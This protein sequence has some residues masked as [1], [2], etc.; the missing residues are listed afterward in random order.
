ME[1]K[2]ALGICNNCMHCRRK[3][4]G[5]I[6]PVLFKKAHYELSVQL[7]PSMETIAI[8]RV[9]LNQTGHMELDSVKYLVKTL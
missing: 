9:Y 5:E 1:T 6:I 8:T 2:K 7:R 3:A 4:G